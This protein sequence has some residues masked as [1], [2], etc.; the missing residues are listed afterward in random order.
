MFY[1]GWC[2]I[3]VDADLY[4]NHPSFNFPTGS[5]IANSLYPSCQNKL[6]NGICRSSVCTRTTD[7]GLPA[8]KS[9]IPHNHER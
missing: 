8:A 9:R 4:S 7:Y 1:Y 2:V 3:T 6:V 5:Y